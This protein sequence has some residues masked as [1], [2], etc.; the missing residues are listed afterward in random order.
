MEESW[1]Y[2]EVCLKNK[3]CENIVRISKRT[4]EKYKLG[5]GQK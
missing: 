3:L 4:G 5:E 2:T 1:I